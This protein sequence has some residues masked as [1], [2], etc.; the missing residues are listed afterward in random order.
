MGVHSAGDANARSLR[1]HRPDLPLPRDDVRADR[2][3]RD[4]ERFRV[5]PDGSADRPVRRF[6]CGAWSRA[7][8]RGDRSARDGSPAGEDAATPGVAA[9]L[10]ARRM[11]AAPGRPRVRSVRAAPG[12]ASRRRRLRRAPAARARCRD[13]GSGR[14]SR[15]SPRRPPRRPRARA[16]PG[17]PWSRRE[18]ASPPTAATTAAIAHRSGHAAPPSVGRWPCRGRRPLDAPLLE[19]LH[20]PRVPPGGARAPAPRVARRR[21]RTRARSRGE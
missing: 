12:R 11:S 17:A 20:E 7:S 18:T 10:R 6:A 5:R 14:G 15:R 9:V 4:R 19:R 8:R 16:R 2:A 1:R 3:P 13:E 21:S